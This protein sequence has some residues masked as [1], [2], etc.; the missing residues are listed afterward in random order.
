M[1]VAVTTTER[2]APRLTQALRDAD[3]VPVPLPCIRVVDAP[4][5]VLERARDAAESA[6]LL[7]LTSPRAVT[8][9][10]PDGGM[11]TVPALCVGPTTA[12][13]CREA[14]G[15]V[16]RTGAGGAQDLVD[17]SLERLVGAN[18][19]F[20]H[21]AGT[22]SSLVDQLNAVCTLSED[23][24]YETEL[25]RPGADEVDAVLFTSPSTV[26]GWCSARTV[27]DLIVVALGDRTAA[28]LRMGGC[29]PDVIPS[30]PDLNAAVAALAEFRDRRGRN[31][32]ADVSS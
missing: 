16:L 20:P 18:V 5:E 8:A 10:W 12:A 32:I 26:R 9:V 21:A 2:S 30:V 24:V 25:L 17:E 22:E 1:R 15:T 29:E 6:T 4:T 13:A 14:G 28:Q 3:F 19:A 7:L 31:G 23:V 11:P 27:S